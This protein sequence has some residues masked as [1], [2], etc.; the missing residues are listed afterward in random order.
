MLLA[1]AVYSEH[2]EVSASLS[3]RVGTQMLSEDV[4]LAVELSCDRCGDNLSVTATPHGSAPGAVIASSKSYENLMKAAG[5]LWVQEAE[6]SLDIT[7][8]YTAAD[9]RIVI[10]SLSS[11][12]SSLLLL[13]LLLS[14]VHFQAVCTHRPKLTPNT[15]GFNSNAIACVACVACVRKKRKR[16]PTQALAFLAVFVYATHA[17]HATKRLRLNGNQSLLCFVLDLDSPAVRS[18]LDCDLLFNFPTSQ[19]V[20]K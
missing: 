20:S 9:W 11:P 3:L 17:T 18:S 1:H 6:L 19:Q 5:Q 10:A 13:L 15:P 14:S 16:L 7:A 2:A 4:A 12:Y 8:L